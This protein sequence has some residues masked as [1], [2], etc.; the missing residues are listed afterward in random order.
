MP[1]R[2]AKSSNLKNMPRD[3]K[4]RVCAKPVVDLTSSDDITQED[5]EVWEEYLDD[6]VEV[7]LEETTPNEY[8]SIKRN[9]NNMLEDNGS[10]INPNKRGPY[11]MTS[12]TTNWRRGIEFEN[13]G[14][15]KTLMDFGFGRRVE[16]PQVVEERIPHT[17]K[18]INDI[19]NCIDLIDQFTNSVM[20]I[21]SE[22]GMVASYQY[23]RYISVKQYFL[24]RLEGLNKGDAA[25]RVAMVHWATNNQDSRSRSI[26]LW[27][28]EFIQ[29]KSLSKHDQGAHI[30]RESFLSFN[31]V[32]EA[33]LDM[34]RRTEPAKRSLDDMVKKINEEIAPSIVGKVGTVC[35]STLSKYLHI[36]GYSFRKNK[37]GVFYDGHER[38][39]VVAYRNVWSKRMMQ[40]IERSD[41]YEGEEMD[42]VPPRLEEGQKKIVFVTHDES[43]F[44]AN[45]GKTDLWLK[46]GENYIRKKGAGLSIMIS[47]FQC[48]CHGTMKASGMTSREIFKAGTDRQGWWTSVD[49]VRQLETSVI[50]VFDQ[51]HPGCTGVFL[52]DHSSNHGAYADDALVV[53]RMTLNEKEYP[54]TKQYQ[55]KD[56][57]VK[58]RDNTFLKQSFFYDKSIE[59]ID[60]KGRKKVKKVRYFKGSVNVKR[61]LNI[62]N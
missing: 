23:A 46:E 39:D 37:K 28:K 33:V 32:K 29:N 54:L 52:F 41:I 14:Q 13:S 62:C 20:N 7:V 27:A 2:K 21:S 61:V 5:K 18:E 15:V 48:P 44:Y 19:R 49:M 4:G 24:H 16:E 53:S 8:F 43:T 40:Y 34:V 31:D 17:I 47:E 11:F 3:G 9:I 10:H 45:D 6:L 1:R 38:E 57:T 42:A 35:I 25:R 12:K 30:K 36:W 22:G 59:T 55:F 51:L 56:T 60:K 58:M 50:K 26:I